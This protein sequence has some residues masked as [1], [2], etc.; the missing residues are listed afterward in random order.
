MFHN[1]YSQVA[2][3]SKSATL[4]PHVLDLPLDR[5]NPHTAQYL[6]SITTPQQSRYGHLTPA[7]IDGIAPTS[8]DTDLSQLYYAIPDT[9]PQ[10][11]LGYWG[12]FP[13]ND[14][15]LR[16]QGPC[17]SDNQQLPAELSSSSQACLPTTDFVR[18]A[19][20][21]R[22]S[23]APAIPPPLEGNRSRPGHTRSRDR[24]CFP[25]IL[26]P[27]NATSIRQAR[28]C[29]I[30][31]AQR[32]TR[33]SKENVVPSNL[34]SSK[35]LQIAPPTVP[36]QQ[37]PDSMTICSFYIWMAKKPGV[38]PTEHEMLCFSLLSGDPFETVRNWFLR[39]VS[40]HRDDDDTGYQTMTIPNVNVASVYHRRRSR[41]NRIADKLRSADTGY[42]LIERDETRP[43]ACTSRCGKKF[44]NKAGWKRHEETNHP[45]KGWR[46][47][48]V[49]CQNERGC[50][51]F[52]RDKFGRHLHKA[53]PT[54]NVTKP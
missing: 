4:N 37:N 7:S 11:M 8:H 15:V 23:A 48:F 24:A 51:Y 28:G 5:P 42:I 50:V 34:E 46:C 43:Y 36:R 10:G 32:P 47:R 45:P 38:M 3:D 14:M 53:H 1:Q 44:G 16:P 19:R 52:R 9:A 39:N 30:E 41:C 17:V 26:R 6:Y 40:S 22:Q 31:K 18:Q 35:G 54:L 2:G 49:G 21:P 13:I 12:D 29:K 27:R 25:H 33:Q 20:N